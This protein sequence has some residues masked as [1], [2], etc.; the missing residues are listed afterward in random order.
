M[1]VWIR[2]IWALLASFFRGRISIY[3]PTV[4]SFH[5]WPNELSGT[6]LNNSRYLTF[7]EACQFDMM[8]RTG[9]GFHSLRK[10]WTP[11]VGSQY[12]RYKKPL[13]CF[14]KFQVRTKLFYW[15]E[16][17]LYIS[18]HFERNGKIM[19]YA[20]V[21]VAWVTKG[22]HIPIAE[23]LQSKGYDSTPPPMPVLISKW[24]ESEGEMH[25]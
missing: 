20:Y 7:T 8:M 14:Q 2:L 10:H 1:G 11:T 25:A 17:W 15:D 18:H 9:Y 12:I 22:K 16:N 4:L 5:V 6:V 19:A 24:H 3:D 21:K 23:W 13:R